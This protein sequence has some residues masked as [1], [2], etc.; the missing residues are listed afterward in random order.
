MLELERGQRRQ[1]GGF[2][3]H[4]VAGGQRR[5]EFPG[6]DRQREVPWHDQTDHSEGLAKGHVDA[7]GDG[8]RVP[9]QPLGRARVVTEGFGH[10]A[11]LPARVAD[12]LA[13]VARL[14]QGQLLEAILD[15]IGEPREQPSPIARCNGPPGRERRARS[16]HRGIGLRHPGLW[17]L[18]EHVLGRRL[19][20][21]DAHRRSNPRTRSQSVTAALKEA[22]STSAL[23]R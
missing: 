14:E 1:L 20:H 9:Q 12:R 17:Q 8:N 6:R 13:H 16:G 18:G 22:S 15:L 7:A 10:H 2:E 19:D 4:R 21:R 11:D 5:A 3:H 23:L